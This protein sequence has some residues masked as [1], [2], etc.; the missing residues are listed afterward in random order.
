MSAGQKRTSI[1]NLVIDGYAPPRGGRGLNSG[2]LEKQPVLITSEPSL[3]PV[4]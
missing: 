1:T 2:L 3:Q 4:S